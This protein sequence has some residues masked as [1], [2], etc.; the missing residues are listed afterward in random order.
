ML[1]YRRHPDTAAGRA[2]KSVAD[3]FLAESNEEL[4]HGGQLAH[5]IVQLGIESDVDPATLAARSHAEYVAG[6]SLV[7]RIR[8]DLVAK[9]I[10]IDR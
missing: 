5:R 2:A 10:A 8:E 4:G 1:R 3:E 7:D 9:R 6:P